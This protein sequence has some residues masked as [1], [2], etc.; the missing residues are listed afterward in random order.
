MQAALGCVVSGGCVLELCLLHCLPYS[1]GAF[2]WPSCWLFIEQL[3][4]HSRWDRLCRD[5]IQLCDWG[6]H[7]AIMK[8]IVA[9]LHGLRAVAVPFEGA[10]HEHCTRVLPHDEVQPHAGVVACHGGICHVCDS[11]C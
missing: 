9:R 2:V 10:L 5:C 11:A 4:L 8:M 7:D 6:W 1:S 3:P